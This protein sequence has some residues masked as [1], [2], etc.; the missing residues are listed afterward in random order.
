[1]FCVT[2]TALYYYVLFAIS[3]FIKIEILLRNEEFAH[4]KW[5]IFLHLLMH[6][7]YNSS[8]I[9]EKTDFVIFFGINHWIIFSWIFWKYFEWI[10]IIDDF[11]WDNS[12]FY[13]K[14]HILL[15]YYRF[16]VSL[17]IFLPRHQKQIY[18]LLN[19][20]LFKNYM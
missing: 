8:K 11:I 1:M 5:E 13:I 17:Y 2:R 20:S 15:I 10:D 16:I 4:I 14:I 18:W 7:N 3:Y 6:F 9:I 19:D 12:F